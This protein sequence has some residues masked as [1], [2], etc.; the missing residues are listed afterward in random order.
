MVEYRVKV[1]SSFVG[2][3]Y[4]FVPAA[5][6]LHDSGFCYSFAAHRVT[7]SCVSLSFFYLRI[8][9]DQRHKY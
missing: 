9:S 8:R 5:A 2:R 6:S 3:G 1:L 4:V 7:V